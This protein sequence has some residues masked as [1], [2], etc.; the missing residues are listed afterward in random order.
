MKRLVL[1][2]LTLFSISSLVRSDTSGAWKNHPTTVNV[3]SYLIQAIIA[4]ATFDPI[5]CKGSVFGTTQFGQSGQFNF[6][7]QYIQS[8]H[9]R[10]AYLQAF[11]GAYFIHGR[12]SVQCRSL[13]TNDDYEDCLREKHERCMDSCQEEFG[14]SYGTCFSKKYCLSDR[15]LEH[16]RK[17]CEKLL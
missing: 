6:Q 8:G 11:G 16:N 1:L 15:Q 4:N 12:A 9:T 2:S 5:E 17:R 10:T 13:D 3:S 14:E 7:Q